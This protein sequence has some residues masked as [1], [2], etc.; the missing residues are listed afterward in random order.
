MKPLFIVLFVLC[1]FF[2]H[3]QKL[4]ADIYA[5]VSNYQGDLQAKR[6]TFN[7]AHPAFGLGLS[8]DITNRFTIRGAASY[9]RVTG[10][11]EPGVPA[12]DFFTRNVN[13]TSRILEAQLA[14]EFNSLDIEE[15]G[16]TPYVFAGVA[17][18]HFSPYTFD[19]TGVKE[20]LRP[21]G[22]EGQGLP[23]YPEKKFY[24]NR[25]M[26]IPMGGGLKFLLTDNLQIG[27]EVGLRKLFTDYLDDVSGT[28]ADSSILAAARGPKAAQLAYRGNE[29]KGDAVYPLGGAIRGNPKS[30]DWY[31]TTM[32][33][34]SYSFGGGGG[35]RSAARRSRMSCPVNVY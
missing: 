3:S 21:L 8:Y 23:Q 30:K 18:F 1:H 2:A 29:A 32:L 6:F 24:K 10:K 25:Q 15:R 19:S 28:Y 5:G 17:A 31:Y 4:H 13:F 9:L 14:L 7:D 11:D 34:I 12:Y 33:K 35:G 27:L 26:S 20:Y 22:T 16:F